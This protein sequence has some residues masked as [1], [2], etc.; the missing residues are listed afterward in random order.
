M[1]TLIIGLVAP[2]VASPQFPF[3]GMDALYRLVVLAPVME[4]LIM[5]LALLVLLHFVTPT[6]AVLISSAGWGIAHS[7]QVPIW[8]LLIWWPFLIFSILFV[9]WKQHSWAL[10]FLVP[11]GAHALQNLVPA[12]LVAF[13]DSA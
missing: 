3:S 7:L 1:L 8:G 12:M 13:G 5:G 6:A 11:M 2:E 10:T 4:T 9:T